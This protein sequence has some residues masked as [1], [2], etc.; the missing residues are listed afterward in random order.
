MQKS[1]GNATNP[2]M[3][4]RAEVS[5]RAHERAPAITLESWRAHVIED[6]EFAVACQEIGEV[7]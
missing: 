1:E 6:Q 5:H 3:T 2:A 4:P 7:Q